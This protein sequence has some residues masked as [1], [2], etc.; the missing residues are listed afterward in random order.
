MK[1]EKFK[2]LIYEYCESHAGENA[3]FPVFVNLSSKLEMKITSQNLV[4]LTNK[5]VNDLIKT[6]RLKEI[7]NNK[8]ETVY[9]LYKILY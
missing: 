8:F 2:E 7:K 4:I 3:L 5:L 6:G 9:A 1:K